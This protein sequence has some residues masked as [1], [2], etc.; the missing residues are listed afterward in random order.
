MTT[1]N[2]TFDNFCFYFCDGL[3][4][5]NFPY[6]DQC[7]GY[8]QL[9]KMVVEGT[10]PASLDEIERW[11]KFPTVDELCEEPN[12]KYLRFLH[13]LLHPMIIERWDQISKLPL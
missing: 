6:K 2:M 11:E 12:I 5:P 13:K 4:D 1:N 9:K 8:K 7:T 3:F 10:Q